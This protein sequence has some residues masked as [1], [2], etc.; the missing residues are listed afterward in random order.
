LRD[1]AAAVRVHLARQAHEKRQAV[2]LHGA[3]PDLVVPR[4][5]TKNGARE[6]EVQGVSG[7]QGSEDLISQ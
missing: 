5:V 6:P 4:S 2:G 3:P 1:S 7:Q